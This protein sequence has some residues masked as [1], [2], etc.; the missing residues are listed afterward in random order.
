M[1]NIMILEKKDLVELVKREMLL[2]REQAAEEPKK[3]KLAKKPNKEIPKQWSFDD[4]VPWSDGDGWGLGVDGP[5]GS[6]E[7]DTTGVSTT[8]GKTDGDSDIED[9]EDELTFDPVDVDDEAEVSS[10]EEPETQT[11][12]Q[13]PEEEEETPDEF[14]PLKVNAEEDFDPSN[15]SFASTEEGVKMVD[16]K[17]D[18][19][20]LFEIEELSISDAK[21]LN[22][23]K[24]PPLKYKYYKYSYEDGEG[25]LVKT[26]YQRLNSGLVSIMYNEAPSGLQNSIAFL[27]KALYSSMLTSLEKNNKERHLLPKNYYAEPIRMPNK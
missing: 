5:G 20:H 12:E 7:I 4:V 17:F 18:N 13:P 8:G 22:I 2:F 15:Y 6:G 26:G 16:F 25:N 27:G 3:D 14:K 11:A 1:S 24:D 21:G 9:A 23:Y 10:E 19:G